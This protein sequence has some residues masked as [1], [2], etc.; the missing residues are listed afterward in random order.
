MNTGSN[1]SHVAIR[2][3][4]NYHPDIDMTP[5]FALGLEA[6][7]DKNLKALPYVIAWFD[8]AY[9]AWKSDNL[10]YTV[11]GI[12]CS[13]IRR[14][15]LYA[16]YQFVQAMPHLCALSMP[17]ATDK[18]EAIVKVT[19]SERIEMESTDEPTKKSRVEMGSMNEVATENCCVIL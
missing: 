6:D 13:E 1:K 9:E 11:V 5:L 15:M 7:V 16:I 19:E 17:L 14:K 4:L 8:E 18:E 2:K 3:I 10:P 12:S